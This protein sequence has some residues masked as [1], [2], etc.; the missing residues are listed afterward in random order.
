LDAEKDP[1]SAEPEIEPVDVE[2]VPEAE[3]EAQ[4]P[5]GWGD[6]GTGFND[7]AAPAAASSFV[8]PPPPPPEPVTY[9]FDE[10]LAR[11]EARVKALALLAEGAETRRVVDTKEF[12]GLT[13]KAS[14]N[15]EEYMGAAT[16][17]ASKKSSSKAAPAPKVLDIGFKFQPPVE[18][19]FRGGRGGR[20]ED[21]PSRFPAGRGGGGGRGNNHNSSSSASPFQDQDFPSL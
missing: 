17:K 6:S 12:E 19:N 15:E 20:G 7:S 8:P 11:N 5:T 13:A 10:Y 14:T 2:P 16:S 3:T 21:R 9:T 1:S 4:E 18:D